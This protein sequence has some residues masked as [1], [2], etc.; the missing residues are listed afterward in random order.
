MAS[1]IDITWVV[2]SSFKPRS[3]QI[4]QMKA[5]GPIWGPYNQ[6]TKCD[7]D[8]CVVTQFT[9]LSHLIN[10]RVHERC[11]IWVTEPLYQKMGNP[12]RVQ[13]YKHSVNPSLDRPEELLSLVLA[14]E[15]YSVTVGLDFNLKAPSNRL[16]K[17]KKFQHMQW[18]SSVSN[19]VKTYDKTQ[20][21][22]CDVST[23]ANNFTKFSNISFDKLKSVL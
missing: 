8:F 16:S 19:I 15:R 2:S 23:P 11:H 9:E 3:G 13:T 21:V 14:G 22:F 12:D 5:K 4:E 1:D 7:L 10:R 20:W 18:L 6:Q 17:L